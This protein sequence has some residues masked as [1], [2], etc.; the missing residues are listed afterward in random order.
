M[1]IIIAFL[2]TFWVFQTAAQVTDTLGYNAFQAGTSTLYQSPN[3][4]Y[5]FGNNG[6]SDKAKAQTFSDTVPYVLRGALIQFGAISY[7]SADPDSKVRVNVY[8][9][10][11]FGVTQ[12]GQSDSIAPD[13]VLTFVDVPLTEL[14]TPGDL[15][16]VLFSESIVLRAYEKFSVGIDLTYL[17]PQDT[18]GLISTTDGDAMGAVNAWEYTAGN[19]WF[20]V[21]ESAF[22]W[23]LDVDL[24][25]FALIDKDDPSGLSEMQLSSI[26]IYPNPAVDAIVVDSENSRVERIEMYDASGSLVLSY[27]PLGLSRPVNISQIASG[28]Y[29]VRVVTSHGIGVKKLVKQ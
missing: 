28:I 12:Y 11:G 18:I 4:G 15:F 25:I 16:Q 17:N 9:N 20:T 24:A 5:A 2:L 27:S 19:T 3:G 6:Y 21:A 14:G 10:N 7:N 23:G 8:D 13:S 22:S 1:R 26:S 29:T